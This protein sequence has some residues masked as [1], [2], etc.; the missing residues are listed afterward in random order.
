MA[1]RLPTYRPP[2][3]TPAPAAPQHGPIVLLGLA[4]V[5]AWVGL[6]LALAGAGRVVVGLTALVALNSAVVWFLWSDV[7]AEDEEPVG[8]CTRRP[9]R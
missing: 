6:L 4:A 8:S 5:L 2:V 9:H 1:T 7:G 3:V